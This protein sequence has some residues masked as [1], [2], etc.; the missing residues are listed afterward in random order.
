[1]VLH[2]NLEIFLGHDLNIQKLNITFF[3]HEFN[4]LH[5]LYVYDAFVLKL[6]FL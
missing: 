4:L 2:L 3:L 6:K 5:L 1:M